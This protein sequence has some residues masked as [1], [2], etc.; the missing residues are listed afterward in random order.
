MSFGL[1]SEEQSE[2]LTVMASHLKLLHAAALLR[3]CQKT[4]CSLQ[5]NLDAVQLLPNLFSLLQLRLGRL[6]TLPAPALHAVPAHR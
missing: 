6:Q 1:S 4:V 5:P 3:L 2:L